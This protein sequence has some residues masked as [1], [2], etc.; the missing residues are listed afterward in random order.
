MIN[1]NLGAPPKGCCR[2]L[3]EILHLLNKKALRCD[4]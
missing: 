2:V 1:P 4:K 3:Q